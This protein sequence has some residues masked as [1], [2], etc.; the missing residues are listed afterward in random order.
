MRATGYRNIDALGGDAIFQVREGR[1]GEPAEF[2]SNGDIEFFHCG[3]T[4]AA[5]RLEVA[6][7]GGTEGARR[8]KA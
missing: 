5:F 6:H 4:E 2:P 7:V 3:S 8:P 1:L